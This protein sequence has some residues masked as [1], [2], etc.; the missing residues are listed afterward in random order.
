MTIYKSTKRVLFAVALCIAATATFVVVSGRGSR[1]APPQ[2][3]S[4]PAND[5]AQKVRQALERGGLREAAKVKGTYVADYNPHWDWG[6]FSVEDLTKNSAAVIVGRFTKKLD[7]R[8]LDGK[9]I[10]TD[11]EVSVD[12][13][14]KGDLNQAKSITV[15][16]PGGRF[17]F[18]DGTS[19]EQLTP[20]FDQPRN[21][22]SYALFLMREEAAPSVFFLSGGPQ[23]LFDIEGGGGVKSHGR[24]EDPGAVETK[25]KTKDDF[26]KV[27]RDNA[28]KWP[29]P[30]KCCG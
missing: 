5:E 8:L 17:Y 10:F 18:E 13:L 14:V 1:P 25:G 27:V 29:K 2:A 15:S 30:G 11:Y 24:P 23:G 6:L 21:G 19:A 9:A 22:R 12:E 20:A 16:I 3:T 28:R 7:A 26:L 4:N